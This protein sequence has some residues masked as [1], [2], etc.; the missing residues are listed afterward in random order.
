MT[1]D[2]PRGARRGTP[3]P[4]Y[5]PPA[6]QDPAPFGGE[7]GAAARGDTAADVRPAPPGSPRPTPDARGETATGTGTVTGSPGGPVTGSPGGAVT[8]T[9]GGA[10][11]G[12]PHGTVTGTPGGAV[13]GTPGGAVTGTP[14]GAVT[15]TRDGS[16]SG[17]HPGTPG[18]TSAP[19]GHDAS[20]APLM[21]HD[22]VDELQQRLSHALAGFVDGPR[23]AV[24]EAD[25][26]LEEIAAHVTDAVSRR[27]RT[28]RMAWQG[29]EAG[30][31]RP[32][33]GA[34]TEQLRLALRDYRELSRRLLHI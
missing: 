8:G 16:A 34:D 19:A 30:E 4:D 17:T 15:G 23:A 24:E 18:G 33:T 32:T 31:G 27:R 22:E 26:L 11:T 28:L 5:V 21:P 3:A 9:Q 7:T 20:E 2:D 29:G 10:V 25:R 1:A 14:G 6:P 13:T 12:S